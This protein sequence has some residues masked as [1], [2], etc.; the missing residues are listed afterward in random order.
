[1]EKMRKYSR[2]DWVWLELFVSNVIIIVA[3]RLC[4]FQQVISGLGWLATSNAPELLQEPDA[5]IARA[6][7]RTRQVKHSLI[8]G[9]CLT[10]SLAL[11]WLLRRYGIHCSIRIGIQQDQPQFAAH[12]WVEVNGIA[13]NAGPKVWQRHTVFVH[14]FGV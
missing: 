13:L 9:T 10:R 6:R 11:Y 8:P 12:A 4:S 2:Y 3:L 14:R 7:Y 5:H 1:M